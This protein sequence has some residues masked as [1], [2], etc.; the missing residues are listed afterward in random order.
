[1]KRPSSFLPR[2]TDVAVRAPVTS[3][4]WLCRLKG[5]ASVRRVKIRWYD[6]SLD[7]KHTGDWLYR[8]S[9]DDE[10]D[11]STILT[12]VKLT[13]TIEPE[14]VYRLPRAERMKIE[15]LLREENESVEEVS[16]LEAISEESSVDL[17]LHN[18][19]N[20]VPP[21]RGLDVSMIKYFEMASG[22]RV[23]IV[24]DLLSLPSQGEPEL[25]VE[26]AALV[27]S[28]ANGTPVPVITRN[29]KEKKPERASVA[30]LTEPKEK[31]RIGEKT[32]ILTH[33]YGSTS[34]D[35]NLK[36]KYEEEK[37]LDLQHKLMEALQSVPTL[38]Q[39]ELRKQLLTDWS[40]KIEEALYKEKKGL[41]K[42]YYTFF[43]SL[44]VNLKKLQNHHLHN[45]IRSGDVEHLVKLQE[46]ELVDSKLVQLMKDKEREEFAKRILADD[47]IVYKKTHKGIV[48]VEKS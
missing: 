3:G 2:G 46:S 35:A 39:G 14:T 30:V 15:N 41:N 36:T 6:K 26:R 45:L 40:T 23:R 42:E 33:V 48:F 9:F 18:N 5:E 11:T 4:F 10:L 44:V 28:F 21:T 22:E 1:M 8:D 31:V 13:T 29:E 47:D 16:D 37:R 34:T 20:S 25:F 32:R 43:R 27:K 12:A 19:N 38:Q 7:D 24:E 17:V